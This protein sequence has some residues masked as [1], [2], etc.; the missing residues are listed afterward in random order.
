[1]M[2]MDTKKLALMIAALVAILIIVYLVSQGGITTP[3][4]TV[5][6]MPVPPALPA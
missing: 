3:P 4:V 2:I 5:S 6:G 1:M